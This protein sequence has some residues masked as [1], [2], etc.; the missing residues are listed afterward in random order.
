VAGLVL[1]AAAAPAGC[2]ALDLLIG[3]HPLFLLSCIR[4]NG[5]TAPSGPH[6]C[7]SFL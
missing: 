2:V 6:I 7:L 3:K 4:M 1:F 5:P